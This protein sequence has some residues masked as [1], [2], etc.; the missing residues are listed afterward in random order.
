MDQS[1][2][3]LVGSGQVHDSL[4]NMGVGTLCRSWGVG[5]VPMGNRPR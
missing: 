4:V 3:D 1:L 2:Y 5:M